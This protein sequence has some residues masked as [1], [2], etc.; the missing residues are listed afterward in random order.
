MEE[1]EEKEEEEKGE[2]G[3]EDVADDFSLAQMTSTT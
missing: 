2:G 1:K 3:G